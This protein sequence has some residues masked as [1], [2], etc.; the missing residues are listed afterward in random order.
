MKHTVM[1]ID[2]RLDDAVWAG[3]TP[4]GGF[5]ERT[6][7]MR[8]VPGETTTFRLLVDGD[9][10]YVAVSCEDSQPESIRARTMQRDSEAIFATKRSAS[11][12][13]RR[14]TGVRPM[15]FALNAAGGRMDYR[16]LNEE[17]I[18]IEVDLVWD[19][20]AARDERGW[21]ASWT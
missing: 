6:P 7:T 11:R 16:G 21:S 19:G 20:A 15:G 5:V 12:S 9:A 3:A 17:T 8:G 13:T 10:L 1:V 4:V 14:A 18:Q 2:G